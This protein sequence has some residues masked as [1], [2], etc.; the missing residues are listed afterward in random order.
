MNGKNSYRHIVLFIKFFYKFF[1]RGKLFEWIIYFVQKQ[2]HYKRNYFLFQTK[3]SSQISKI[4]QIKTFKNCTLRQTKEQ[5]KRPIN[6]LESFI[7]L[8]YLCILS[9]SLTD[10]NVTE[11]LRAENHMFALTLKRPSKFSKATRVEHR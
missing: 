10:R 1:F 11:E 4:I 8:S 5:R 7:F 2:L 6:H 3:P 9:F